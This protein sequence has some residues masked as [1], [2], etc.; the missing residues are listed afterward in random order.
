MRKLKLITFDAFGTILQLAKPV[1]FVYY[2]MARKYGISVSLEQVKRNSD[3]AFQEMSKMHKKQ[4][5][6]DG[7]NPREW[8]FKVIKNSFPCPIP[9]M[10]AEDLWNHYSTK[11]AYHIHPLFEGFLRR[12][13]QEKGYVV[14]IISNTDDRIYSV[15]KS[16][17]F[18]DLINVY[19]FS[20]DIGCQ[21]PEKG[22][23]EYVRNKT[24][25][26]TGE[27]PAP[28]ECLH[29]G[30]DLIKDVEAAK[31]VGWHGEFCNI[32]TNFPKIIHGLEHS[33][34]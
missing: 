11:S 7:L 29:F 26:L 14:G 21:K 23:F 33:L 8:W 19:A 16:C 1:P 25:Q 32:H 22:I 5:L 27:Y 17:G 20:Y 13:A 9:N 15:F 3:H 24:G 12:N 30:D 28:K 18:A 2:E 31:N 6:N 10:M 34:E 4:G